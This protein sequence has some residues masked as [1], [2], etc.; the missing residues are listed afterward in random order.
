MDQIFKTIFQCYFEEEYYSNNIHKDEEYKEI[1]KK[2]SHQLNELKILLQSA[3]HND[4]KV[5]QIFD[6]FEQSYLALSDI[7][8]Y[9]DFLNGLSIGIALTTISLQVN[10]A[11]FIQQIYSIIN[12][13]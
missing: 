13:S 11:E 8:R 10:N 6:D 9:H 1:D 4:T 7:Y 12:K 5:E 2:L 3:V